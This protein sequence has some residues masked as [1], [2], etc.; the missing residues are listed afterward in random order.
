M[1]LIVE[2]IST[3]EGIRCEEKDFEAYLQKVSQSSNQ[4]VDAVKRYIQQQGNVDS[5]KEW[6]Q[7]EKSLDFLIA[8]AKLEAA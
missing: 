8:A 1:A 6:I 3:A 7:Y 4:P 5:I 2:K